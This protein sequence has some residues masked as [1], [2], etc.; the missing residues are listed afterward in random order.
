[1][2]SSLALHPAAPSLILGIPADWFLLM[3]WD[4]S[5]P[6]HC[7][8]IVDAAEA[9]SSV[10]L[11]TSFQVILDQLKDSYNN[12]YIFFLPN[13]FIIFDYEVEDNWLFA[14]GWKY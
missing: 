14:T 10:T 8:V 9:Q 7:L 1:M 12:I 13:L 2:A 6:L 5:T 4:S 3:L 11:G